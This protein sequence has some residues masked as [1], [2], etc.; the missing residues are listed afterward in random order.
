MFFVN[1][2]YGTFR[3]CIDYRQ[4]NRVA[5]KNKYPFSRIDYFLT[6]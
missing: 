4:F 5:M 3:L 1:K 2:K 6:S